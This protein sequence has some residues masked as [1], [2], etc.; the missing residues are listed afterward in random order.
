MKT[1]SLSPSTIDEYISGF[2][3][4]VQVILE[5]IRETIKKAAPKAEET[6]SY[7]IP[8]FTLRDTYLIYFAAYK[9]HIAIYPVPAGSEEFKKE[10]SSY[11]A[12]KGTLR[13]PLDQP[14]PYPLI[15]KIVKYCLQDN[16]IRVET[17]KKKKEPRA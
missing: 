11:R 6:I 4:D 1:K 5:K 8:T 2:P 3:G 12:G 10:V 17:R 15:R 7:G 13:F 16:L 9:K 14:L